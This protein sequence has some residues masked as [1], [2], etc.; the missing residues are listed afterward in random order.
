LVQERVEEWSSPER[1]GS[2]RIYYIII[3]YTARFKASFNS[4]IFKVYFLHFIKA[5][6]L[7]GF[8]LNILC[9]DKHIFITDYKHIQREVRS[10]VRYSI[11]RGS[12]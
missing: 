11:N 7:S 12:V 2:A 1:E 9:T 4:L 8:N 5:G 3:I 6:C 10:I